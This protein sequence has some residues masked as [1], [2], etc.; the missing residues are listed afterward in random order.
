MNVPMDDITATGMLD[1][2]TD[3]EVLFAD[4]IQDSEEMAAP[5]H[6]VM[7]SKELPCSC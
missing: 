1:A 4:A 3:S 7:K 5:V 6:H 2:K